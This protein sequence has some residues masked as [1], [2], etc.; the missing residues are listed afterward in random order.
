M[1]ILLVA[2]AVNV[3]QTTKE[4]TAIKVGIGNTP[5]C[6]DPF[7]RA[8]KKKKGMARIK[9]ETVRNTVL[10]KSRNG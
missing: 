4:R 6:K 1:L 10:R 3:L 7:S 8:K 9:T 2:T 5:T